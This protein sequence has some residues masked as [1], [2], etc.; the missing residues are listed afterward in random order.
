M[1]FSLVRVLRTDLNLWLELISVYYYCC[2]TVGLSTCCC[3]LCA[4][5]S[6]RLCMMKIV[7]ICAGLV[8]FFIVFVSPH[9]ETETHFHKNRSVAKR[10]RLEYA[11]KVDKT[12]QQF[13][14]IQSLLIHMHTY[15]QDHTANMRTSH[16]H[17]ISICLSLGCCLLYTSPSPRDQA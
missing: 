7:C 16:N 12:S 15:R 17:V 5:V 13:R 14:F 10:S 8:C 2:S 6:S 9:Q 4:H 3:S 11:D 1:S